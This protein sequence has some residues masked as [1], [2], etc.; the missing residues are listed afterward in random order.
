M[1]DGQEDIHIFRQLCGIWGSAETKKMKQRIPKIVECPILVS[2]VQ[3]SNLNKVAFCWSSSRYFTMYLYSTLVLLWKQVKFWC[4]LLSQIIRKNICSVRKKSS[5]ISCDSLVWR[6][7]IPGGWES[8][9]LRI[10]WGRCGAP[11]PSCLWPHRSAPRCGWSGSLCGGRKPRN[12]FKG[13]V[14]WQWACEKIDLSLGEVDRTYKFH[15]E[16]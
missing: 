16:W 6:N 8:H 12:V 4:L 3:S 13:T 7:H 2:L 11:C 10:W 15:E 1:F 14:S 5:T 9:C